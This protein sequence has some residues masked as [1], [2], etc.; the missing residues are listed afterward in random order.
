PAQIGLGA[1]ISQITPVFSQGAIE[2][3]RV[4]SNAAIQGSG[5]FVLQGA[6]GRSYT[7]AGDFLFDANGTLVTHDGQ[8]VQGFTQTDPTTGLIITT[9]QPTSITIPPGVLRPPVGTTNFQA[10]S[11]LDAGSAN[12]S[13]FTV[14]IQ[15]YDA[16]GTAHVTTM[17]YTK[18]GAG[19]W[20]YD[21]TV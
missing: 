5:F 10:N 21:L 11:N 19:A 15:I 8:F 14:A 18:T 9:S 3:T 6:A 2:S 1:A 16:L 17:T 12:A 13:T 7:R 20:T 4:V